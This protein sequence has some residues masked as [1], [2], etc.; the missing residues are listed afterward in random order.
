[1]WTTCFKI[2]LYFPFRKTFI[3]FTPTTNSDQQTET[4]SST[5]LFSGINLDFT[6]GHFSCVDETIL[7]SWNDFPLH[8]VARESRDNRNRFHTEKLSLYVA[9]EKE[10]RE[11]HETQALNWNSKPTAIR[12][13]LA[14]KEILG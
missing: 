10:T 11:K 13:V 2:I 12:Y 7:S 3:L 14:A 9:R 4:R 1:M 6:A 8:F 5:L